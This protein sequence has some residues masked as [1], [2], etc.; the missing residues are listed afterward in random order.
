VK[1]TNF[2]KRLL[3][4]DNA[5]NGSAATLRNIVA[6]AFIALVALFLT[7]PSAEPVSFFDKP[8]PL[9]AELG[10]EQR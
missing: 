5:V 6:W 1:I 10:L 3:F 9:P 7:H 2:L 4:G 8:I